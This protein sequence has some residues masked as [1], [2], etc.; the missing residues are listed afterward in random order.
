M[1][2]CTAPARYHRPH[3]PH[4]STQ[5]STTDDPLDQSPSQA[6]RGSCFVDTTEVVAGDEQRDG[7]FMVRQLLA[8]AVGKAREA[9]AIHADV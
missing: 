4:P 2:E 9:S 5:R 7:G 8:V 1:Q 3:W 6:S